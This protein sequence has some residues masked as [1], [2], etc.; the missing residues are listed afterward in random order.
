MNLILEAEDREAVRGGFEFHCL[1][2]FEV[3][4]I[5]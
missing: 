4:S 2:V 1:L 5:H 3:D